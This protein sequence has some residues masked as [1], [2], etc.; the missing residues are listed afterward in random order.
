MGIPHSHFWVLHSK[1]YLIDSLQYDLQSYV[2]NSIFSNFFEIK[3]NHINL[4]LKIGK[5]TLLRY[6]LLAEPDLI[7]TATTNRSNVAKWWWWWRLMEYHEEIISGRYWLYLW[8]RI[9]NLSTPDNSMNLLVVIHVRHYDWWVFT[10]GISIV[11][12]YLM[13]YFL[14][15][16]WKYFDIPQIVNKLVENYCNNHFSIEW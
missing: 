12:K 15:F 2:F 8:E 7:N 6:A 11:M 14:L 4:F 13:I 9:C 1:N 5:V 3:L 10:A 16:C